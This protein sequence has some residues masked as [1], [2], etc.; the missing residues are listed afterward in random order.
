MEMSG[1]LHAPAALPRAKRLR[2]PSDRNLGGF[3]SG[4]GRRGEGKSQGKGY[5]SKR[6]RIPHN[7]LVAWHFTDRRISARI[8]DIHDFVGELP[9]VWTGRIQYRMT[10][11]ILEIQ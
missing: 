2:N 7:Q 3:Q 8:P 1:H 5:I 6:S 4:F 9:K 10:H 11:I